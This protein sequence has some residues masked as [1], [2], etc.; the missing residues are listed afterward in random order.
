MI[1]RREATSA[2]LLLILLSLPV[3]LVDQKP[4]PGPLALITA[5][6]VAHAALVGPSLGAGGW[7]PLLL[8][9]PALCATSYGHPGL[10]PV[11]ASLLLVAAASAAGS[12]ARVLEARLYLPSMLLVFFVPYALRYLVLEFGS[13]AHAESWL[14]LSPLAAAAHVSH[15]AWPPALCLLFLLAWPVRALMRRPAA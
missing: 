1:A 15:G 5:L 14:Q 9:L 13:P 11:L 10:R 8:T 7:L 2:L 4:G 6:A 3:L 12:A